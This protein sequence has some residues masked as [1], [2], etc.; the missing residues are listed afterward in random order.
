M[1]SSGKSKTG[2]TG[3][4]TLQAQAQG[5]AGDIQDEDQPQIVATAQQAQSANNANFPDTDD[6][7][8]RDYAGRLR[9]YYQDQ[10]FAIDTR[11]AIQDY[12]Y[13]Q[14][15]DGTLY[16]PSQLMN[17]KLKY[18]NDAQ[19]TPQEQFMRDSLMEGMHNLGSNMILEHYG[20]DS[21]I[22]KLGQLAKAAGLTS[23]TINKGNFDG[24]SESQ[25]K[26]ALVG[27]EFSERA[28]LS[29]SVNHF[30]HAPSGNPFT[31]KVVKFTIKAPAGAQGLMPGNG[32][33]G[34]LGEMILA[35]NQNYRVTD[36]KLTGK[37]GR[38]GSKSYKNQIEFVVEMF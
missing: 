31:D 6:Q 5:G 17:Y 29:T 35:P 1:G 16:S 37:P 15:V 36:V 10:T 18:G 24:M 23:M 27:T 22:D 28:F 33:G 21:Y 32:P 11:M 14:P 34:A 2:A 26:Q 7:D 19:L 4:M 30:S 13:D 38:S 25:L 20:R 9:D 3:T 12:L 8:Y